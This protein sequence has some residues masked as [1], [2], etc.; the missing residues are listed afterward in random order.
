MRFKEFLREAAPTLR[1]G[2]PTEPTPAGYKKWG[3]EG[4]VVFAP[5]NMN[6]DQVSDAIAA[7]PA[8]LDAPANATRI[9]SPSIPAPK[10]PAVPT[11][12]VQ[13]AGNKLSANPAQ[14]KVIIGSLN[15]PAPQGYQK[16]AVA[17]QVIYVL[18]GTTP[19]QVNDEIESN[20]ALSSLVQKKLSKAQAELSIPQAQQLKAVAMSNG[21][22][23]TELT[24]LLAQAA[25]E[26]LNFT[27]WF[28]IMNYDLESLLSKFGKYFNK[29][30]KLAT[31][32]ANKPEKIAN[33][34]YANRMGNGDEK[35]GDGWK[36]RGRGYLH[37]TGKDNYAQASKALNV[38]LVSNPDLV[39][40]F[41]SNGK[42]GV[43]ELVALW[44]W[45]HRVQPK[46]KSGNVAAA[47]R[48]IN[49]AGQGAQERALKR[50]LYNQ[51][52]L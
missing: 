21:I 22:Q 10:A 17:G 46:I 9:S 16:F 4:K 37:L 14:P 49:P 35:S 33:R 34:V 48:G 43:A 19:E 8:I 6:S 13:Q 27:K 7:N 20:P 18:D 5:A 28:E 50:S 29:S 36:Y 30:K 47:T 32:Y 52:G 11:T 39:N 15:K 26:S 25:H 44:Y 12:P 41:G 38:D 31:A 24:E 1:L 51:P 40:Q 45:K 2:T 42:P 23:G 3:V